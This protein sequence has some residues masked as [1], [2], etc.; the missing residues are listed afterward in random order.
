MISTHDI[1]RIL[2]IEVSGIGDTIMAVPAIRTLR[3]AYPDSY[4][5]LMVSSRAYPLIEACPYADEVFKFDI[6]N[7]LKLMEVSFNFHSL[8]PANKELIDKIVKWIKNSKAKTCNYQNTN[9]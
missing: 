3:K 7:F 5:V 6:D 8:S 2:V 4:I 1:N 9:K